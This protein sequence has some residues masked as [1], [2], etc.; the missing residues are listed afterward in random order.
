M[1]LHEYQEA[2]KRTCATSDPHET[3]KL[4]LIGLQDELGELAGPLK[5]Y[6]WHGHDLDTAHLQDEVGDVLW[7]LATL[8]TALDISL[9]AALEDNIQKLHKR[10]PDGFSCESSLHRSEEQEAGSARESDT[11]TWASLRINLWTVTNEAL[12]LSWEQTPLSSE[13]VT[14]LGVQLGHLIGFLAR[15]HI[16]PIDQTSVP[17]PQAKEVSF[18]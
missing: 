5:K 15:R 8:C 17:S 10:Y 14:Y 9:A 7:Y 4:A 2:V 16:Y 3:I 11:P 18:P 1:N 13:D 6:L 12:L